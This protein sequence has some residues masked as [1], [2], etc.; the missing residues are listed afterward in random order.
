MLLT[1]F[2]PFAL[3][4]SFYHVLSASYS[5]SSLPRSAA[6]LCVLH[7]CSESCLREE[8]QLRQ[9]LCW[10]YSIKTRLATASQM[11][12]DSYNLFLIIPYMPVCLCSCTPTHS[13]PQVIFEALN[14]AV[15]FP[16]CV[17]VCV[18]HQ[19]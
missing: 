14:L 12:C 17:C 19:L 3:F 7:Y 1:F 6:I 9:L 5:A 11:T 8:A 15:Y 16:V 18:C 2:F 4:L 10:D 13:S